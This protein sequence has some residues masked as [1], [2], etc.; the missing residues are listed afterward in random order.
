M[1]DEHSKKNKHSCEYHLQKISNLKVNFER[2]RTEVNEKKEEIHT[3]QKKLEEVNT[4]LIDSLLELRKYEQNKDEVFLSKVLSD[5]TRS[6]QLLDFD[7]MLSDRE[8][9][10][11][12]SNQNE[13]EVVQ[14]FRK[15]IDL[16]IMNQLKCEGEELKE[17]FD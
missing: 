12:I 14:L 17:I 15:L 4:L 1:K 7:N 11:L 16:L 8:E 10:K 3:L 2:V 13:V 6:S 9:K 5:T